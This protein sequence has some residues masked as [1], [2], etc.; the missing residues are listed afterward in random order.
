MRNIFL[1]LLLV[2]IVPRAAAQQKTGLDVQ[3]HRGARGLLP[4]N[5]IPAMI[6]AVRLGVTTLELDV[7]ISADQQVVVSH[8]P[9]MNAEICLD[10]NGQELS[11]NQGKRLNL[12]QMNYADI[13]AYDCGSKAHSRFPK[14]QNMPVPKPLLRE[15]IEAVERYCQ[16]HKLPAVHFNIEI[17]SSLAGDGKYHPEPNLFAELVMQQVFKTGLTGRTIIQSFDV[18]PL[19]Y[20][21]QKNYPVR[22]AYL[23]ES[24][25]NF[26]QAIRELGFIPHTYSPYYKLVNK[27]LMQYAAQTGMQVIPWTIN[28]PADMRKAIEQG[29]AGIITDYPDIL[30]ELLKE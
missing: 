10:T 4:E 25:I 14:Q 29:V 5:T 13:V 28:E 16:E 27:K 23:V 3:G 18:R 22:I 9:W 6:E 11:T 24:Q 26:Q 8:E 15:L 7:V 2:S 12:Y 20:I 1:F 19:Q 30:L 17:K 21:N